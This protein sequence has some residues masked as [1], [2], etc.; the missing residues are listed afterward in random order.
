MADIN[1]QNLRYDTK[2]VGKTFSSYVNIQIYNLYI[3]YIIVQ[4]FYMFGNFYLM[5][6][7]IK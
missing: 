4:K 6:N 2:E 5:I 3:F 7:H 1:I